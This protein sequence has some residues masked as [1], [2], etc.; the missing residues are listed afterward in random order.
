MSDLVQSRE[1]FWKLDTFENSVKQEMTTIMKRLLNYQKAFLFTCFFTIALICASPLFQKDRNLPFSSWIPNGYP[2]LYE[3]V[4][5]IQCI[6]FFIYVH[7]VTGFDCLFARI[8]VEV[9]LQFRLLNVKMQ[10]TSFNNEG[11]T[12]SRK[13]NMKDMKACIQHHEFLLRLH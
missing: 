6:L 13:Q 1:N 11:T 12:A 8:C 3:S 5:V 9:I 7:L 10:N 2:Y 4:Y